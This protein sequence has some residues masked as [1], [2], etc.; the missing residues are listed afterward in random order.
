MRE[1]IEAIGGQFEIGPGKRRGTVV[2]VAV[3]LGARS[4]A[5]GERTK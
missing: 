1:R 2:R 3:P 5:A 4:A